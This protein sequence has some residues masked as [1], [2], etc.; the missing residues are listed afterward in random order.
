RRPS[1]TL[2]PYTTLFRSATLVDVCD[3][4]RMLGIGAGDS[5]HLREP[6]HPPDARDPTEQHV[7]PG[8]DRL[9]HVMG[10]SQHQR[11]LLRCA[12]EER[13]EEHTSELQSLAYLV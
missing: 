8:I 5:E 4:K 9:D 1:S 3:V 13:S 12:V 7:G 10:N 2:F 11:V 6:V